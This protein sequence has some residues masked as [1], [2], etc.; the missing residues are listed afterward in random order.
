MRTIQISVCLVV[1]GACLGLS[2]PV[3]AQNAPL[4]LNDCIHLALEAPSPVTVAELDVDIAQRGRVV[5]RS[6]FLPHASFGIDHFYNSPRASDPTAVSFVPSNAIREFAALLTVVQ[7][8]DTSGRVRAEYQRARANQDIAGA[9]LAIAERELKRSVAAAYYRVLLARKLVEVFQERVDEADG[10]EQRTRVRSDA[11]E[12]ARAD[13]VKATSQAAS[14]RQVLSAARTGAELANQALASFWT[15]DVSQPLRLVDLID[16]PVSEPSHDPSPASYLTRQE[17]R[18][19]DAEQRSFDADARHARSAMRPQVQLAVQWGVDQ[20]VP[21]LSFDD[22]GYAALA[23]LRL[24]LFDWS[25][26]SNQARQ[27]DARTARV[28]QIREIANRE[29]AREYQSALVRV[30]GLFE[31]I[32]LA[33]IQGTASEEDLRLSR[34]RYEGGEGLALEV[35]TAAAQLAEARAS[36]YTAIADYL[37]ARRDLEV[38]SGQ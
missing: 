20:E 19:F 32:S 23:S 21:G 3:A 33:R 30:R 7:D 35:V 38:A 25:R 15:D 29:F 36:Y 31:Q 34:V 14:F 2:L 8:I 11:G 1:T 5:A 13:V 18:L 26:A 10:F 24:T 22:R 9:N 37:T 28:G 17:F 27:A 12:A 4:S 6:G 16:R